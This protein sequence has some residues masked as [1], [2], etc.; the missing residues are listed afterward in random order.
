MHTIHR[1][2]FMKNLEESGLFSGYASVYNVQD[3]HLEFVMPGAFS[4]T[5]Q[6]N[7][8]PKLLWQHDPQALIGVWKELVE[9]SHGLFVK[10][11]IFLE[12]Q[13]GREAYLL[14]KEGAVDGLSI[15][16]IP[17]KIQ[18]TYQGRYLEQIDLYEISLVTFPSNPHARI[19]SIKAY[20]PPS[21]FEQIQVIDQQIE[22][23]RR[24]L[25]SGEILC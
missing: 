4:H 1:P 11:K 13:K 24:E 17:L 16:Y 5:L 21:F 2:F 12:L 3:A 19:Q 10:G 20:Q 18:E 22:N 15:G 8:I 9:D 6:C 14:M 23:L 7:P 25:Q